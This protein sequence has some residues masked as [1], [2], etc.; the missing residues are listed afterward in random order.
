MKI[1]LVYLW[2][3]GNDPKWREKKRF[4][5]EKYG[6]LDINAIDDCRF[7]QHDE[8]KFSLRSV[9][10][11]MP[12]INHIFI[13]TDGQVPD[14]LD[15]N[16]SK[17]SIIDHKDIM[18]AD[19]LP[20]FNS[21]AI[22][23][24]LHNIPGLSEH[25]LFANDDMFVARP[26]EPDFFFAPDGR[27]YVFLQPQNIYTE[28]AY[29]HQIYYVQNLIKEKFGKDYPFEPHHNIDAYRLSDIKKCV[30]YFKDDFERTVH[31]RFR[32]E[33]TM[34]RSIWGYYALATDAGILVKNN[35]RKRQHPDYLKTQDRKFISKYLSKPSNV[36]EWVHNE[37]CSLF[38]V[39]DN[40]NLRSD[41]QM[42]IKWTLASVFPFPSSFE[43]N[44]QL[45]HR[46]KISIIVPVYNA[47]KYLA[48]CLD[49]LINQTLKDIEIICVNDGS[50]DNSMDIL[51]AYAAKDE[52]IKI[53]SFEK[54]GPGGCRNVGI[55]AASG[56]YICFV[57]ADD[58]VD[59]ET[60]EKT[61]E[62]IK[63]SAADILSF[64]AF[65]I[66]RNGTKNVTYFGAYSEKEITWRDLGQRLF[67]SP[68]H[69]W[70][71][72]FKR[73]FLLSK[74]VYFADNYWCEDVPFVLLSLLQAEKIV[75][76]PNRFYHYC[77]NENSLVCSGGNNRM[78]V[79]RIVAQLQYIMAQNKN[80]DEYRRSFS[81]WICMHC[82]YAYIVLTEDDRHIF[83]K[84]LQKIVSRKI[85]KRFK[86]M[87]T[88]V[89]LI[90]IFGLPLVKA[91]QF[92]NVRRFL[93]CGLPVVS[94]RRKM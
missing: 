83:C 62:K 30:K 15:T 9:E 90:K 93:F 74:A 46:Y 61:Y 17:I 67:G 76:I 45:S 92:D 51:H 7:V 2:C 1:D 68:F 55:D 8:L 22:E 25:F 47:A 5:Q 78:A 40:E 53:I 56:E 60:Y 23:A 63:N 72:L 11:Y 86:K 34:Q 48:R 14:W 41:E 31:Q 52:R 50:D 70:H 39:N 6:N 79:L 49:S 65:E 54:M 21:N 91:T 84:G 3:D 27:P 18:P 33:R 69:S 75:L 94:I 81:A 77:R 24:C 28:S 80:M 37:K 38:C 26:L 36:P 16:N 20:T 32:E 59:L 71:M 64:N 88:K 29:A 66:G 44:L 35:S 73:T 42:K 10:M 13:V 19:A 58:F 85:F 57:D 12:W 82:Y 4:W 43:K 87:C 89:S